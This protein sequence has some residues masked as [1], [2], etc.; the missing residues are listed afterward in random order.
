M[1]R[2]LIS[3]DS[4]VFEPLDL[5]ATRLPARFRGD[6]PRHQT[7]NGRTVISMGGKVVFSLRQE[8]GEPPDP[9]RGGADL[10]VRAKDMEIDGVVGEVIYP[11]IG[12]FIYAITDRELAAACARVYNDWAAETFLARSDLFAPVALIPL[13]SLEDAVAEVER[14][15]ALGFRTASPPMH[16]PKDRPYSDPAYDPLWESAAAS[17][18]PLSLHVGTGGQPHS[19]RG[20]GGAIINY[21]RVGLGAPDTIAYLAAGGVLARHPGLR[22]VVAEAGAGWLAYLCERM[23][24]AFEEHQKWVSPKLEE[25]PSGYLRRQVRVTFGAERAPLLTREVTSA[26][27]LMWASDYPHPEGTWPESQQRVEKAC[28]GLPDDEV[29]AIVRGNAREVY[30]FGGA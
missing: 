24:E 14:V 6:A 27:P 13:V 30:R 5:W 25:P 1:T 19:E 16:A 18:M 20:P 12:L 7:A 29:D 4:H 3:A 11:T 8:E 15:A 17:G 28:R 21:L 23:D 22:V 10:E 9:N 2:P 26:A